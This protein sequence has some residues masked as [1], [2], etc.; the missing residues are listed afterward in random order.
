VRA[1]KVW[2]QLLGV[3]RTVIERVELDEDDEGVIVVHVRPFTS[4]TGR[5]GVC[6]RRAPGYDQGEGRRRWRVLDLGVTKAFLEAEAPRVHCPTDGVVVAA[7]PWARH[8]SRFTRWFE[9][10]VAWLARHTS[11]HAVTQL[12]RITWRTVGSIVARVVA[13]A[14]ED[15]DPF[16]G[17]TRIGIDEIS[18]KRGQRYLTVVV[19]HD[20]GRLVWAAPGRDKKTLARFFDALGRSRSWKLRLVSA[21]AAGWIAAVVRSR[22]VNAR[23]VL[24]PFH[25]VAWATDALDEVRR[26][27]WNEARQSGATVLAKQVKGARFALWRNPD[28]LTGR[29]RATLAWVATV[30]GPLYRAWL[31]KEELRQVFA[32]KG[33]AGIALLRHWL[34]WA[35]RCRI[36]PFVKLARSIR[37]RLPGIHAT[38]QT[39][40][41]NAIVESTNTKLRLLM[42]VA[43]GYRDTDALIAMAMLD[44][45]GLCPPLPGR[46]AA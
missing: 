39:G 44:R 29:Q 17:L 18:F 23:L 4:V 36:E 26:E 19:D 42:R 27:V 14:R 31:L 32:L 35:S 7:V 21:D 25:I 37:A 45:G 6:G 13:A 24:D 5:C 15:N 46:A 11:K 33:E 20:S 2:R 10:M 3:E 34:G 8:A 38:L 43:F 41:S 9:D 22:C 28:R 30:N 16:D 12:L 1:S 40:L